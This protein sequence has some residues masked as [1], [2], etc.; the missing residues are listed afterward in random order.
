MARPAPARGSSGEQRVRRRWRHQQVA[1]DPI[2]EATKNLTDGLAD[3]TT[4]VTQPVVKTLS[5]IEAEA[6]L[7]RALVRGQV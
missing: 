6:A 4:T 3:A 2:K 1:T 5:S 7:H